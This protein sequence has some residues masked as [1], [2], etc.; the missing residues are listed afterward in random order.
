MNQVRSILEFQRCH[1]N[2]RDKILLFYRYSRKIN[3]FI[4]YKKGSNDFGK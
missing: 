4:M 1:K 3:K 2:A